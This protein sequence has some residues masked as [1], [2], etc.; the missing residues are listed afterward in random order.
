MYARSYR[1]QDGAIRNTTGSYGSGQCGGDDIGVPRLVHDPGM[2]PA[3]SERV[4][5]ESLFSSMRPFAEAASAANTPSIK[6][7]PPGLTSYP[8]CTS[9]LGTYSPC[10]CTQYY[11]V[12]SR[13]FQWRSPQSHQYISYQRISHSIFLNVWGF[14]S[15]SRQELM[16]L[17]SGC[18]AVLVQQAAEQYLPSVLTPAALTVLNGLINP[19]EVSIHA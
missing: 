10:H 17:L 18:I 8:Q 5:V 15:S 2:N 12:N 9:W 1:H 3:C 4:T 16:V 13:P 7:P 14:F 11:R 6:S 19:G